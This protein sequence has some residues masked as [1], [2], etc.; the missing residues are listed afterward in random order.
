[1]STDARQEALTADTLVKITGLNGEAYHGG[2]GKWPLPR[3]KRPGAWLRVTGPLVPCKNGLH[4]CTIRQ[5]LESWSGPAMWVVETRGE[6][7]DRGSN[8]VVREARLLSRVEEWNDRTLRLFSADCAALALN[9]THV[10]DGRPWSA[11]ECARRFADGAATKD[12]LAAAKNA[13][14]AD[15]RDAVR[16]APWSDAAALAAAAG[17]AATRIAAKAAAW[18]A[19]LTRLLAALNGHPMP[20]VEREV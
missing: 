20:Q 8:I 9:R 3:G 13:A 5:A 17:W 7:I 16:S 19:Q 15:A 4:V 1:M 6:S 12:E 10:T 2:T 18:D 11:V 14:W